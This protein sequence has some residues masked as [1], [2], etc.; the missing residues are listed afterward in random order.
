MSAITGGET[1]HPRTGNPLIKVSDTDVKAGHTLL[2]HGFGATQLNTAAVAAFERHRRA[3]A[4]AR[5]VFTPGQ[6]YAQWKS[7]LDYQLKTNDPDIVEERHQAWAPF[8]D[9]R[10][11]AHGKSR[12]RAFTTGDLHTD[13]TLS[14]LSV[15]YGNDEYIGTELLP[16][17]SVAKESGLY[18]SYGQRDRMAYPDDEIGASGEAAE[19]NET[20]A[21]TTYACTGFAYQNFI[22]A[23]PLANQ[24]APLNEMV[25]LTESIVEGLSFRE[26]L[27]CATVMTTAGNY[28][29]NTSALP[30]GSR[31]NDAGGGDPIGDMQTADAALWTGRGPSMKKMFSSLDVYHILSRHP[32]ILGLFITSGGGE[33]GLATPSMIAGYLS[34]DTYLVGRARQDTANEAAAAVYTRIWGDQ[35]GLVRVAQNPGLR[36]AYFGATFRWDLAGVPDANQGVVSQQWFDPKKG[37]GGSFYSKVGWSETHVVIAALCG[38][39]F[40]TVLT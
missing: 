16:V 8:A 39:L 7:A 1:L 38:Y 25:D 18:Q 10:D 36:N 35:F 17:I 32:D 11:R 34:A 20:R 40:S 22:G 30:P 24:D 13:S 29:A 28:G 3:Q 23:T 12:E 14:N 4:N 19:I 5:G 2:K 37:L 27:R 15:Q 21:T 31:W 26:E 6:R 33:P 9:M